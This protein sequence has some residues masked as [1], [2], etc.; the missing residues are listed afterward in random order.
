M[1]VASPP[2]PLWRQRDFNLYWVGQTASDMG[3]QVATIALPLLVLSWHAS[4][5]VAGL[6]AT[7]YLVTATMLRLPAGALVDRWNRRT[8]MLAS[9]AVQIAGFTALSVVIAV[10]IR[11]PQIVLGLAVVS[12]AAS[13]F[14]MPAES[15]ALRHLVPASQLSEAIA[16]NEARE[17]AA[18]LAGPPIGGALFAVARVAPF[19]ASA[20]VSLVS[21]VTLLLIRT[22]MVEAESARPERK[23]LL[24]EIGDGLGFVLRN[25]FLRA[26][27][28]IAA[29]LN[30]AV[31]GAI[32][33]A[34]VT[35]QRAGVP[36]PVIG[37]SQGL[38]AVGGLL[39]AVAAPTLM[40]RMTAGTVVRLV[41]CTSVPAMGL[42]VA[43]AGRFAMTIPIA[44]VFLLIPA[45]N[46]ALFGHQVSI[47]PDKLQGRVASAIV[48]VAQSVAAVAPLVVGAVVIGFGARTAIAC[49]AALT[50][51]AAGVACS[52]RAVTRMGRE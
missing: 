13:T 27:V 51:V 22:P 1:T 26:M 34:I 24:A 17:Y 35:L 44:V 30:A 23:H 50:F 7:T 28:A 42:T 5:S 29:P 33:A 46:A 52:S 2:R 14:F 25:P 15:G 18:N 31:T 19:I 12:A 3:A 49:L 39:G 6:V 10:D 20:A 32:F 40:K 47:T 21:L 37:L 48:F 38:I 36:T 16:R 11:Q 4:P 41:T 43:L 45:A 8:V 9:D